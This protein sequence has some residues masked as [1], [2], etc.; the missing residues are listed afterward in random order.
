MILEKDVSL[1]QR[2]TLGVG[3]TAS[4]M[5]TCSS[6]EDIQE[7]L[8]FAKRNSIGWKMLGAG[9]NTL[10]HDDGYHGVV[11]SISHSSIKLERVG[12]HVRLIAGAGAL[13]ETVVATALEEGLWGIENLSGIPGTVG[14]AP[15]QNIGAYGCELGDTLEYVDVFDT[16]KNCVTRL[17]NAACAFSYRH[18]CFKDEPHLIV[19]TVSLILSI[20]G[21]V[22]VSYPEVAR[23]Q[24]EEKDLSTPEAVSRAIR[25][26]RSVKFP[27]LSR[28]G[29]A[30]SFFKNP[31]IAK[32]TYETLRLGHPDLPGF[33]HEQG[34]K[35]PLAFI[36][37]KVLHL[38]GFSVGKARLF[39]KQPLVLVVEKGATAHDVETLARIVEER[40]FENTHIRIEREVQ[41][42]SN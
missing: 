5:A 32:H 10:A 11:I 13:W 41:T 19:I 17:S 15:I 4:Y 26:I 34:I 23:M 24:H 25:A 16:K 27:D 3:G 6:I 33:S 42:L 14:A 2:T 30:G 20:T 9:S 18:S 31:I 29:T 8:V 37:D 12:N 39:E 38:K 22:N 1:A 35:I 28:V 36:L 21:T 7:A 40:V